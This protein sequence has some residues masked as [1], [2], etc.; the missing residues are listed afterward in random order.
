[1]K[2]GKI[3]KHKL[4]TVNQEAYDILNKLVE[5]FEKELGFNVP[6]SKLATETVLELW[7]SGNHD[8]FFIELKRKFK[9]QK[10]RQ[11]IDRFMSRH[12]GGNLFNERKG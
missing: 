1:M 5:H 2:G 12:A 7:N 6:V 9:H 11:L 8:R 4:I 10:Q 3:V